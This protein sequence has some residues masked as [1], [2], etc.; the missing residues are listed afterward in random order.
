MLLSGNTGSMSMGSKYNC[1]VLWGAVSHM[2]IEC[3]T[4]V[5]AAWPFFAAYVGVASSPFA[6]VAA[7]FEVAA[8]VVEVSAPAS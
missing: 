3:D 2:Y 4:A 5:V 1:S 7:A 6:G 8:V